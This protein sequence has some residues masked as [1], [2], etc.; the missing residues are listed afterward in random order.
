MQIIISKLI[1][2]TPVNSF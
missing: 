1:K 2:K